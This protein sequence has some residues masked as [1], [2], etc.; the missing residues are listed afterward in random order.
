[1]RFWPGLF[2]SFLLVSCAS[3]GAG[4]S[5]PP[6]AGGS[7][8]SAPASSPAPL[9]ESKQWKLGPVADIAVS[10]DA[11]FALYSPTTTEGALTN[12]TDTRLARIDRGS[13]VVVTAGPFPFAMQ[14]AFAAGRVWIGPINQYPGA[15]ATDSRMLISVDA[16]T[17]SVTQ[18]LTL[19]AEAAQ[20]QLVANL[21]SDSSSVWVAYGTHVYRLD[22]TSGRTIA[23]HSVSGV[24]TGIALDPSGGRLYV[25][26]DAAVSNQ[27]QASIT[28]F[29]AAALTPLASASTGGG[30]LGGPQVA[31][32]PDDVWVSYATG[33]MG[34]VEHRQASDLAPLP[35]ASAVHT[36]GVRVYEVAGVVWVSDQMAGELICL[37]RQSGAVRAG[38]TTPEG[39]V[40]AGDALGSYFGDIT[41]LASF[42]PDPRCR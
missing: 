36:N 29:E 12:A 17:L 9:P 40:V 33:M 38:W 10:P 20:R 8:P 1:M 5:S 41:G 34:Q 13:G 11:I 19:P 2:I 24:A 14:I 21:A 4:V 30:D 3:G 37:N 26:A 16:L 27:S 28:E 22:A 32:G 18:R 6:A 31:A 23:S 39:G 25:G 35:L 42:Q 15:S 7:T